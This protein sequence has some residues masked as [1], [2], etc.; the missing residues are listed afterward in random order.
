MFKQSI[1]QKIHV[2]TML[3]NPLYMFKQSIVQIIHVTYVALWQ[4]KVARPQSNDTDVYVQNNTICLWLKS[5][6]IILC[7]YVVINASGTCDIKLTTCTCTWHFIAYVCCLALK[8]G[9][10]RRCHLWQY[11]KYLQWHDSCYYS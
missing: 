3:N 11:H 10:M 1:V 2:I 6:C 7:I 8:L 5:L 4:R 9:F